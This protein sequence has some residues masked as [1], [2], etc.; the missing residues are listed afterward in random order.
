MQVLTRIGLDRVA[1]VDDDPKNVE[2]LS[3][4]VETCGAEPIPF[5]FNFKNIGDLINQVIKKSDGVLCDNRLS[6]RGK[7]TF[8]GAEAVAQWFDRKFPAI[9][10][11]EFTNSDANTTI[12]LYRRKIP[13]VIPRAEIS[14][15]T[16]IEGFSVFQK[17]VHKQL[18]SYRK[19]RKAIVKIVSLTRDSG[20]E[21]VEAFIPQWNP[22]TAIRFPKKLLANVGREVKPGDLYIA[23][24]NIDARNSDELYFSNFEIAPEPDENDGLA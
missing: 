13:V 5:V 6:F 21:I 7:A 15:Q 11:S 24:V 8:N 1:I 14:Q 20:Y 19:P 4:N 2:A 17:E 10:V 23:E 12:R 18:P 22:H 9:L 16:I 3:L